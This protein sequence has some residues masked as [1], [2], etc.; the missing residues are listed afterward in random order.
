MA[1]ATRAGGQVAA[2][3]WDYAAGMQILRLFWDAAI[4]LHPAAGPLDEGRRFPVCEPG[5]L[6]ALFHAAHLEEVATRAIEVA[7]PFREFDAY[8]SPFLGGQGPAPAYV[9]AL[10]E[11]RRVALR[12]RLRA[13]VPSQR[14]GSIAL[15]AR[16]WAVRGVRA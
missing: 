12:E 16:A 10:D 3:V 1:R 4:A 2:Y 14:D 13:S 5:A 7:T 6:T 15:I 8:W 9:M 11:G